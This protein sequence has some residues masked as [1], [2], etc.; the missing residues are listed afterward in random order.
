MTI[1]LYLDED[2]SDA[3]LLEALRI[4]GVDV[5]AAAPSGRGGQRDDDQLRW[6]TE[7]HRVLYSFNRGDFCRIHSAWMRAGESHAGI[8]LAVQQRYSVGEQMRRLLRLIDTLT[9]EEMR[10]RIEFLSAWT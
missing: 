2:T 8:I 6:A 4:R 1:R 5:I 9:A 3:D 7:Q 10:N